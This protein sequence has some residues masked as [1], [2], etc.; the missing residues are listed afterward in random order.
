MYA[1]VRKKLLST[2]T[3]PHKSIH[4]NYINKFTQLS[5]GRIVTQKINYQLIYS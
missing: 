3:K 1:T 5:F 4:P 2:L